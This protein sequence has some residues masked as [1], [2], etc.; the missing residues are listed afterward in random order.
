MGGTLH[1]RGELPRSAERHQPLPAG[2]VDVGPVVRG[3]Q[4][5]RLSPQRTGGLRESRQR[6]DGLDRHK[7]AVPSRPDSIVTTGVTQKGA[8]VAPSFT[9]QPA[10]ATVTAAT[11]VTLHAAATGESGRPV[12][13]TW[14]E[15]TAPDRSRAVGSG[16]SYS[17]TAMT[18][19]PFW[20]EAANGCP[21][22][23]TASQTATI[24]VCTAPTIDSA[25]SNK[26]ITRGQSTRMSATAS[27]TAP[28]AF[29]W[30]TVNGGI[31]TAI[32]GATASTITV[33]PRQTTT[34][35]VR[36]SNACGTATRDIVVTV[37]AAPAVPTGVS[38][39]YEP[40]QGG[41]KISWTASAS[42]AGL[43]GYLVQRSP[44]GNGGDFSVGA[45][46]TSY[47]D[48][49]AELGRA[50]TYTV[51]SRDRNAA[52]SAPSAADFA[53]V[54]AFEDDPVQSPPSIAPTPVRAIHILRL[55]EAV[56]ALRVLAGLP[57]APWAWNVTGY[58]SAGHFTEVSRYLNEARAAL[59][60]SSAT[61]VPVPVKGARIE[62]STIN[63][64][65]D[66]V[67]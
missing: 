6:R 60:V 17:F 20:V 57:P 22:G 65:R 46:A 53:T 27:G 61:V 55:R 13:Y 5:D 66:G 64:L 62:G 41:V 18:T 7:A 48:T 52:Y 38:A 58:V 59:G 8:C 29:Q 11:A 47:V 43:A 33:E 14:F 34:Y 49:T 1:P 37:L 63:S 42:E 31:E 54:I 23:N 56:G 4:F 12:T 50:Y 16:T 32:G 40:A 25:S 39:R 15:G 21:G 36:V 45:S 28:V 26:T 19:S 35:R 51:R 3:G 24:T 30:L 10:S 44:A 9:L 67:R 2:S